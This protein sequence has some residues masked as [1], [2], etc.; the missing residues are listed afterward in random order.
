LRQDKTKEGPYAK[1]TL[2]APSLPQKIFRTSKIRRHLAR[3]KQQAARRAALSG[4]SRTNI[5]GKKIA[6]DIRGV[7]QHFFPDLGERLDAVIDPRLRRDY[8]M[9]EIL[10]APLVM[11]VL[12]QDSR[13]AMDADRAQGFFAANYFRLFQKR[14][15]HMDTVDDVLVALHNDELERLKASLVT[16]LI[17]KKV[18]G[19]HRMTDGSYRVAI[20]ATGIMT[21]HE[22]HCDHC[23]RS[24]S[25]AGVTRYFH[26]MLEAKLLTPNGFAISLATEWIENEVDYD[27]QDCELKAF[28]RLAETL[29]RF[30]PRLPICILGDGLYANNTF[31]SICKDKGWS[32]IVTLKDASLTTVWEDVEMELIVSKNERRV[33]RDGLRHWYRWVSDLTYQGHK[34]AWVEWCESFE[35]ETNRFVYITNIAV[36][37]DLVIEVAASGRLR[38]KVENE[39]FNTLKNLGYGLS[40]KF[41]RTSY[42]AL[43][44]YVSLM[45]MAHLVNQLYELS[46]LVR[47]LPTAK[48][49][50]KGLWK[51]LISC[52]VELAISVEASAPTVRLQI[53]YE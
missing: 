9:S 35:D 11:F 3:I 8:S 24:T 27:K 32:F 26:N 43:K 6:R 33:E 22:G 49:T 48:A 10:L 39:G 19:K 50:I 46:S 36:D 20:D 16:T 18:L 15:P 29:K 53:R 17:E 34:L 47:P 21:V 13:N 38:F 30:F 14:L 37:G 31:F 28:R 12:K 4:T 51:R 7:M 2:A 52:M 41:T 25:K 42:D 5:D 40:K 23:L 45:Q 1:A 44:N